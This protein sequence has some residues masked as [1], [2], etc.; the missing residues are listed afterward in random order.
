MR[1]LLLFFVLVTTIFARDHV[2]LDMNQLPPILATTT[3][4]NCAC[5]GCCPP[6]SLP[7]CDPL[8]PKCLGIGPA[9]LPF[10]DSGCQFGCNGKC[11]GYCPC[12][13]CACCYTV[14]TTKLITSSRGCVSVDRFTVTDTWTI[15]EYDN[16]TSTSTSFITLTVS[17]IFQF[18]AIVTAT[19]TADAIS[20]STL[21]ITETTVTISRVGLTTETTYVDQIITSPYF[22]FLTTTPVVPFSTLGFFSTGIL[23]LTIEPLTFITELLSSS[24]AIL[25]VTSTAPDFIT[26]VTDTRFATVA[27]ATRVRRIGA[28]TTTVI[29]LSTEYPSVSVTESL[30]VTLN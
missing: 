23:D 22:S 16:L 25:F 10:P 20:T 19:S 28:I 6:R 27:T 17:D 8:C 4:I 12:D 29:E 9:P 30:T 24:F 11:P 14:R 7:C 1:A 5:P 3:P 21:I 2:V 15:V 18:T 13:D 26:S